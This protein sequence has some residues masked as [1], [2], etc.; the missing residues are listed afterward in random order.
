M[1]VYESVPFTPENLP[2]Y[3]ERLFDFCL[4]QPDLVRLLGWF[5]LEQQTVWAG[6]R[7]LDLES[8]LQ[9]VLQAQRSGTVTSEFTPRFIVTLVIAIA[10]AWTTL[11]PLGLFIDPEALR[12]RTA[13]R[14]A[15]AR[16]VK[17]LFR[18]AESVQ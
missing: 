13:T 4:E 14:A 12:E 1:D 2:N 15:V 10:S 7:Q 18:S 3:A 16:A 6:Q 8:K 11:N 5:G 9:G 17:R